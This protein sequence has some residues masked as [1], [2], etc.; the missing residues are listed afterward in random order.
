MDVKTDK[1]DGQIYYDF[2]LKKIAQPEPNT[3]GM[4][5]D[6][7]IDVNRPYK[8]RQIKLKLQ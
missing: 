7:W 5:A 3:S 2:N 4:V 8:G 1:R 6:W